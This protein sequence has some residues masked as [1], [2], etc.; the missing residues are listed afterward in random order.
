MNS[1]VNSNPNPNSNPAPNGPAGLESHDFSPVMNYPEEMHVFDLSGTYDR[2][3]I[4]SKQWGIGKYNERRT[5]MYLAPQYEGKRNIH[6]G[7]DIW[8]PAGEP[9]YAFADGEIAWFANHRQKGNYG[10]VIVTRQAIAIEGRSLYALYGHLSAESLNGLHRGRKIAAGQR[11][12]SLGTE[13]ENGGW[14]PHLHFQLSLED[15]GEADMPGVVAE[16]DRE[17]ALKKFPDP[18]LVLGD[19]Y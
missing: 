1:N 4:R 8:A 14:V 17:E 3:F 11:I 13:E 2:D 12:A 6:M 18:R 19:L 7:I 15:P 10:P 9:V 16:E 5:K